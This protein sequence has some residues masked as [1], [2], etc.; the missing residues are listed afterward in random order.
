MNATT[1]M[2]TNKATILEVV[3]TPYGPFCVYGCDDEV[4]GWAHAC[5]RLEY[6]RCTREQLDL[7]AAKEKITGFIDL[8]A[9]FGFFSFYMFHKHKVNYIIA[10]D[11][12]PVRYGVLLR[13]SNGAWICRYAAVAQPCP[14]PP[15][16]RM[17][18]ARYTQRPP[19]KC[20]V[21]SLDQILW[22]AHWNNIV[23]KMDLEGAEF[24][25]LKQYPDIFKRTNI[26][27]I[28]ECHHYAGNWEEIKFNA[29]TQG[30]TVT[31]FHGP[32]ENTAGLRIE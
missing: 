6:D 29:E 9:A 28:I 30:R 18:T 22:H 13:N 25:A 8:G 10:V 3:D 12:D 19:I 24:A 20:P 32:T 4:Q 16:G 21:V 14:M 17:A 23:V 27:W 7:L 15:I 1:T 31:L 11:C 2:N 5:G 26:K